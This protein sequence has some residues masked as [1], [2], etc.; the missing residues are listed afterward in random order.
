M[1]LPSVVCSPAD[2]F[3]DHV[4][5]LAVVLGM[6]LCAEVV[7]ADDGCVL[8]PLR[9][10]PVVQLYILR[11]NTDTITLLPVPVGPYMYSPLSGSTPLSLSPSTHVTARR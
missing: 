2:E 5:L 9:D 6:H 8:E 10:T 3:G 7:Y 4:Y 1:I 11:S